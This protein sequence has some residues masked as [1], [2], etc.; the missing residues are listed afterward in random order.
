MRYPIT[1][2]LPFE[3][4]GN[5]ALVLLLLRECR[6]WEDLCGRY[7]GANP[8]ELHDTAT[9]NLRDKLFEMRDLGLVSFE[10]ETTPQGKRPRGE[11]METGLWSKIRVSFGG[12][13]MSEAAMISRHSKG[14]AV[15]PV[16]GRPRNLEEKIDVFVLMPFNTKMEKV[17][18][19]HIKKMG[20]DLGLAI[21]RA[22][23]IV[24]QGR[25]F[26]EAVWDGHL[27]RA[28]HLCRLHREEP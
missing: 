21:R 15:T 19:N 3:E 12:M 23:E 13:S 28:S 26:M 4:I 10:D 5:G 25:P 22:D 2:N 1:N 20:K 17:Y 8:A 16:F 7:R 18:T 27:C 6:T 11:I 9:M 24:S 14:M